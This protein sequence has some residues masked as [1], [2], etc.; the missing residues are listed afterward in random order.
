[1]TLNYVFFKYL[2]YTSIQIHNNILHNDEPRSPLGQIPLY[3]ADLAEGLNC[4]SL[5]QNVR[6]FACNFSGDQMFLHLTA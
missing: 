6:N 2:S 1:M 4:S 3:I 5:L